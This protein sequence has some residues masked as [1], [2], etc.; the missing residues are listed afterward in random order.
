MLMA[1]CAHGLA[2][3][4]NGTPLVRARLAAKSQPDL[5]RNGSTQNA[6]FEGAEWWEEHAELFAAARAEWG[7]LHP[8]LYDLEASADAFL[9]PRLLRAVTA[10]E[11]AA[12]AGGPPVDEGELR[13]LLTPA[14]PGVWRFPLFTPRFCELLLEELRHAESSGV[15][16]RRVRRARHYSRGHTMSHSPALQTR[17]PTG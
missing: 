14:A 12:A 2:A 6:E 15:P 13:A 10:L 1:A 17:S 5:V 9:D 3:L 4:T 11:R 7:V 16:L 8:E